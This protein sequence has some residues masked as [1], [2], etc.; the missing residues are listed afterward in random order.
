[1]IKTIVHSTCNLCGEFAAFFGNGSNYPTQGYRPYTTVTL[2]VNNIPELS[3]QNDKIIQVCYCCLDKLQDLC[4]KV[5]TTTKFDG[6][7]ISLTFDDDEEVYYIPV[8]NITSI[9]SL[10]YLLTPSQTEDSMDDA[11]FVEE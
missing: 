1:M 3:E 10:L 5:G 7:A 6:Q 8:T 9:L 4:K 11:T 2:H